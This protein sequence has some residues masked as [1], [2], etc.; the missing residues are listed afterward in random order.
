MLLSGQYTLGILQLYSYLFLSMTL[1]S[2]YSFRCTNEK[3]QGTVAEL[4][5]RPG[6]CL[7]QSPCPL[8]LLPSGRVTGLQPSPEIYFTSRWEGLE[9][10]QFGSR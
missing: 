9:C 1:W 3:T 10:P 7:F 6:A 8:H 2:E 4:G 5:F